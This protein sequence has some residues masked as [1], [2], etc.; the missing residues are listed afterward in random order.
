MLIFLSLGYNLVLWYELKKKI[1]GHFVVFSNTA[2]C[3]EE[4][5]LAVASMACK[6]A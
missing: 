5:N 6:M 1:M 2:P 3:K 4:T